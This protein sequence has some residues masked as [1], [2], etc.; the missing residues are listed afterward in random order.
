LFLCGIMLKKLIPFEQIPQFA[1]TDLAYAT[2]HTALTPFY[3]YELRREVFGQVIEDKSSNT[4]PRADLVEVLRK[5]YANIPLTEAT[6]KNIELLAA[7]TTYTVT[8][9]HQPALFLGPLYYLYKAVT[10]LNL[11]DAIEGIMGPKYRIVP[12]F[13]LGSEDHDLDELNHTHLFNKT[14]SWN[15]NMSGPVG[16]IPTS[17]LKAPLEM[18]KIILGDSEHGR[19][20]YKKIHDAYTGQATFA[21]ATQALLHSLFGRYGLVVLDMNDPTLKRHFVPIMREELTEKV[22]HKHVTAATEQLNALGFKTQATP[23]EINLF[24]MKGQSRERIVPDGDGFQVLN[25]DL[26]FTREAMLAELE[27][28]PEHFS[29]NVVLRPLYQESILPN[30]AYVGGGGELAYWLERKSLFEHFGINYPLLVRR[31]SVMWLDRD[32]ARKMHK[33]GFTA[34]QFFQES[35]ALVRQFIEDNAATEVSLKVEMSEFADLYERIAAKAVQIDP[36]LESAVRAEYTRHAATVEQLQ[37]R[38]VRAEKQ[39]HEVTLSQ[40][41]ALKEK[42][43]PNN[44]LQERFDSF[45]PFY[46][47]Y[48]ERLVDIMLEK[49]LPLEQGFVV[50]EDV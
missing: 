9:A 45:M 38:L 11:A 48:G 35:D 3:K 1:K 16:S 6:Q 42:F 18:I 32:S 8:T 24:Y 46:L 30:L 2:G 41:R 15:P 5:Q 49:L 21:Q 50:L 4:V 19:Q 33:F 34:H 44:G 12:I 47:R 26:T 25:T 29:P 7:D 40:I 36:T 27:A 13:V 23:R 22:S 37:G 31:N 17:T 10:T 14:V 28:H 39:K 43:F 20:I